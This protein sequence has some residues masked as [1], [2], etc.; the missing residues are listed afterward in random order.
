LILR[1]TG[2][3]IGDFVQEACLA[4]ADF[5]ADENATA[6]IRIGT[7]DALPLALFTAPASALWIRT[8]L[9]DQQAYPCTRIVFAVTDQWDRTRYPFGTTDA[10][11][12]PVGASSPASSG[13][14]RACDIRIT[15]FAH[16]VDKDT[17]EQDALRRL[18]D[19]LSGHPTAIAVVRAAYYVRNDRPTTT[20][21]SL[22]ARKR[23]ARSAA[24]AAAS[25]NK[26]GIPAD[27]IRTCFAPLAVPRED[28]YSQP[29]F[30]DLYAVE[31]V[32]SG[33]DHQNK[34]PN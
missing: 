19:Y 13:T 21:D 16:A 23:I 17:I 28:I 6:F 25:L 27:H 33:S 15:D 18:A 26:K 14:L 2:G 30:C 29:A 22:A 8:T 31:I 9:S 11:L 1:G 4:Y 12:V 32:G 5:R 3:N 10:W 20:G 34:M 7:D 24:T